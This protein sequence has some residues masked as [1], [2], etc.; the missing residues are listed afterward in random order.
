MDIA[1]AVV[2][3]AGAAG[4]ATAL[5]A[6]LLGLWQARRR[7]RGRGAGPGQRISAL[8]FWAYLLMA[9]GYLGLCAALWWP[10][11]LE[12]TLPA[13]GLVLALGAL[14]LFPGLALVLWARL[15]LGQMYGV[16]GS[17]GVQLYAGHRLVTRGPFALARHPMYLGL[18][19]AA[20]GGIL[21]YRTWTP[22]FLTLNFLGFVFRARKEEQALAAEFGEEWTA[23]CRRVPAWM[24]RLR[25]RS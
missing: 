13:R 1:E 22:V 3:W 20:L 2:R 24:P 12:L 17:I 18:L 15:A 5:V 21:V 11:P 23:Y 7:P 6:V 19:V 4:A 9:A 10:I 25:H 14:L 16:S 8:P